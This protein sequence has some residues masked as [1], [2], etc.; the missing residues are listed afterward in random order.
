MLS[1]SVFHCYY[2]DIIYNIGEQL[3]V[4]T[5]F[6]KKK[7]FLKIKQRL[8]SP[9]LIKRCKQ[10]NFWT[11][12]KHLTTWQHINKTEKKNKHI[13]RQLI[14]KHMVTSSNCSKTNIYVLKYKVLC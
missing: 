5:A 11:I 6:Y 4:E 9:N 8:G 13:K 10:A 7:S 14:E 3:K 1:E 2:K 12:W